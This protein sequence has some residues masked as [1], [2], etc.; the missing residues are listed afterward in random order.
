MSLKS[1]VSSVALA[2]TLSNPIHAAEPT[3]LE[4]KVA[5]APKPRP[6][7]AQLEEAVKNNPYCG[8]PGYEC[9]AEGWDVPSYEGYVLKKEVFQDKCSSIEGNETRLRAY[10]NTQTGDGFVERFHDG[11][12]YG[13]V[14]KLSDGTTYGLSDLNNDGVFETKIDASHE[15]LYSKCT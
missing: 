11:K 2:A 12:V 1:L 3:T 5:M 7:K 15:M 8:K 10:K 6:T 4:N 9:K 14:V 13:F